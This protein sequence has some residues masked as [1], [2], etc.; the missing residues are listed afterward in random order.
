MTEPRPDDGIKNEEQRHDPGA[1]IGNEPVLAAD[2][3]PEKPLQRQQAG[4]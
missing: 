2:R 1:Y 4:M 3:L